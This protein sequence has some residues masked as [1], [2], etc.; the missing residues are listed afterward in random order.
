M[1]LDMY[2]SRRPPVEKGEE[3]AYWRKHN[4]LHGWMEELWREKT[5]KEGRFNSEEV[6]LELI[7]ITKKRLSQISF[8]YEAGLSEE[9]KYSRKRQRKLRKISPLK[10]K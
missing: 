7:D 3:I 1:G 4:R 8:N 6:I 10:K 2:A 5:G 9:G